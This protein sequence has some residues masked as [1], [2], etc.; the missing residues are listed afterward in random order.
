M[1]GL[2]EVIILA[3]LGIFLGSVIV[4]LTNWFILDVFTL[5]ALK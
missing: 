3:F 5:G 1:K 2:T 4:V